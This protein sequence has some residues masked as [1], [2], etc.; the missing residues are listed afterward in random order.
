MAS[1]GDPGESGGSTSRDAAASGVARLFLYALAI[2]AIVVGWDALLFRSGLYYRWIEPRSTAGTTRGAI[3][4]VEHSYD[5]GRRN[6]LVLGNSRIGEGFSSVLA[7]EATKGAGLHF[8]N[9][10]IPGTDPRVWYYVLRQVDAQA[11]HFAAVVVPVPYDP[12]TVA[13][14]PADYSLDIA[15]LAPWLRLDDFLDFPA[16]FDDPSLT[17]RARRAIAFPGQPMRED[18]AALLASPLQRR[19]DVS[20]WRRHYVG[21]ALRYGGR[22]EALPDLALDPK[23]LQPLDWL[24]RE[25]ELK[26]KLSGYLAAL[27]SPPHPSAQARARNDDYYREWLRRIA[28]PYRAHGVP[29]IVI[30]V[31]R[32]PFHGAH[33]AVPA[34]AGAVAE[35]A[36]TGLLTVLPGD[37]FVDLEQPRYFF[38]GLHL[39]R[40]GREQF[41]PRLAR[42]V[43][44]ALH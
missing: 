25:A 20:I 2:A 35:L 29:V 43:A 36:A 44:T 32:G 39:N 7:D 11:E 14:P 21:D 5:L 12:E 40:A 17:Q 6:V 9:A 38:D 41:S 28:Q 8:I 37:S 10:A 4:V 13:A 3:R 18:V 34:A 27:A 1:F 23:T 26:P 30:E 22:A 24:G 33:A 16:S 19:R 15:Y 31:P 42:L